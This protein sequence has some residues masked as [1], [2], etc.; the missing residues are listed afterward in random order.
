MCGHSRCAGTGRAPEAELNASLVSD[1]CVVLVWWAADDELG[2]ALRRERAALGEALARL[3]SAAWSSSTAPDSHWIMGTHVSG[4]A[5][6]LAAVLLGDVESA[7]GAQ[8][9]VALSPMAVGALVLG[10]ATALA[11]PSGS[12][13][14]IW[15]VSLRTAARV[16]SK[17]RLARPRG[18]VFAGF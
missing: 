13:S 17:N 7:D 8:G 12:G 16:N 15:R 1:A 6:A 18:G 10:T 4:T 14:F 5:P 2:A 9:G 11:R 3:A